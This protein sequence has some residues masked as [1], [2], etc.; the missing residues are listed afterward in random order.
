MKILKFTFGA[1]NRAMLAAKAFH[2]DQLTQNY[3]PELLESSPVP[4]IHFLV[5]FIAKSLSI[6]EN[7]SILYVHC[8]ASDITVDNLMINK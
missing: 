2:T 6:S 1:V 4:S 7:K 5:D 3:V 8:N